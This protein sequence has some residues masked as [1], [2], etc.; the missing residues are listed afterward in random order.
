[1]LTFNLLIFAFIVAILL[2]WGMEFWLDWR[3]ENHLLRNRDSLPKAYEGVFSHE[4][5]DK[6]IDYTTAKIRF[7]RKEMAFDNIWLVVVLLFGIVPALYSI[8]LNLVGTGIWAHA[9][10]IFSIFVV[11]SLPSLPF[12]WMSQFQLEER[13]GFNKSTP[14][15][16]ITDKIKGLILGAILGLPLISLLLWL[17]QSLPETWWLWGFIV[18][19]GFQL[20]MVV[21]YPMVIVPWFNKLTPLKEGDLRDRLMALADRTGFKA[22]TIQMIDGSKRSSHS[23]AYFTGFGRFRRIVLYDT[24]LEQL[25]EEEVEAVLAHEI[26]H[27][28]L[29]HIPKLLTLSAVSGLAGFFVIFLLT[30]VEWFVEA[31]GFATAEA[32]SLERTVPALI[33]F[34]LLSGVLTYW[35]SPLFNR[36]SR[37]HEY[38]ADA[39]ARD[40]V[41]SP[42]P[43]IGALRSLHE[44]NL[45]NLLPDP[46][47]SAFHYSHPTL[48]EREKAM[49]EG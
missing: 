7:G 29:G 15:L 43:L 48:L 37:K 34:M 8:G 3:N 21:L 26:G 44:K 17:M 47:Y 6:S 24:L 12:E 19:F 27:Y 9:L 35:L 22:Q 36:L 49:R 45:S 46:L 33:M 30:R 20:L 1:M 14:K 42:E 32:G 4:T 40:A 11:L 39:F 23:N 5:I 25:R 38:E 10:V 28:R 31:F 13:F 18:F 2:R 41:K 16:W